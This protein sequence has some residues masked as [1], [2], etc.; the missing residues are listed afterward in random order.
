[1]YSTTNQLHRAKF[2]VLSFAVILFSITACGD[3]DDD[4]PTNGGELN[5]EI[6]SIS[7]ES[8]PPGTAVTI[9]GSDFSPTVS[10][11][12]VT[13]AGSEADVTDASSTELVA[14]VPDDAESGPVEVTVD[15][16]TATGPNFEV[17]SDSAVAI[18]AVVPDSGAVGDTITIQGMNFSTTPTE[19]VV[20]FNGVTATVNTATVDSLITQ[21]PEGATDGPIEVSVNGG[22][23][24]VFESFNVIEADTSSSDTTDTTSIAA[25]IQSDPELSTLADLLEQTDLL[26]TL[27]GEG[28]Y[29]ILAPT[30]AVLET[31]PTYNTSQ[32]Q[33]I[34]TYHVI[35]QNLA[36]ADF[37]DGSSFETLNGDAIFV[38]SGDIN[39]LA[40]IQTA[41]IET[42]NGTI[43]KI[44]N[45]LL[46]DAYTNVF[47]ITYK[48]PVT[49]KFACTCVSGADRTDL[50]EVLRDDSNEFT[51]FV[52]T[53]AAFEN[54]EVDVDDLSNEEL[55]YLMD[56][57]VVVGETLESGELTDGMTLTMR[58][59]ETVTVSVA[60]DGTISVNNATI[61]T[62]DLVGTNG[63]V[64]I[65]D[66]VMEPPADEV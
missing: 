39:H 59:G 41:D 11:N 43:H 57:H 28:P 47:T 19:N 32:L 58:N 1:M 6:T 9:T 60:G 66:T 42:G 16:N 44:D 37:Q 64:H 55:Q 27:E 15:G 40:T 54:R 62:V 50:G 29:T 52:P 49:N 12:T 3:D 4:G 5:P 24:A 10:E 36:A 21:V 46:P 35:G 31:M 8:G 65:I 14:T 22:E 26:S 13:F 56:Y 30:N 45:L 25:G 53:D 33:D 23:P 17:L 2:F 18:T 38:V 20:T 48:R 34:L 51:V 63:V 7:P 61:Q